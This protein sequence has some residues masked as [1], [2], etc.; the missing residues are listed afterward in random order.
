MKSS[1]DNDFHVKKNTKKWKNK[2]FKNVTK[3]CRRLIPDQAYVAES[4]T[5]CKTKKYIKQNASS[6]HYKN[7]KL[8]LCSFHLCQ[9]YGSNQF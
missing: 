1:I 8:S 7:L 4:L 3:W 5:W 2:R 9:K 6:M